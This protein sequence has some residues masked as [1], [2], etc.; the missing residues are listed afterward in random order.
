MSEDVIAALAEPNRRRIVE[1]LNAAPRPV[2][3]VAE[4]LGLRQ[5]LATKHLQALERA[6]LVAA[7]SLGR[8]RIYALNRQAFRELREWLDGFDVDH[9][10]EPVLD[11]YAR[12]IAAERGLDR[13]VRLTRRVAAARAAVWDAWTTPDLIRRWWHPEHFTVAECQANPVPGGTL[14]IVLREGGGNRHTASGHYLVVTP[15]RS[16]VFELNPVG[17]GGR[18]LFQATH[19]L[20]LSARG[21][22]TELLLEVDVSG[23][24]PGSEPALAGLEIGWRQLLDNLEREVREAPIA[25]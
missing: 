3:E 12:M 2:G 16:L 13:T 4:A 8:R 7:Y 1:L 6:G 9:P 25:G 17:L 21:R 19:R 20:D 5:P 18:P 23:A 24:V 14:R 22:S 11:E 10:S 15:P